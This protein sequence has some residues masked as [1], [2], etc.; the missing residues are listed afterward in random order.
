MGQSGQQSLIT[1]LIKI[2]FATAAE[3][4]D[5][6]R[7]AG[8][9]RSALGLDY[10]GLRSGAYKNGHFGFIELKLETPEAVDID[11]V[12]EKLRAHLTLPET[13]TRAHSSDEWN[14][15]I[16]GRVPVIDHSSGNQYGV[17]TVNC[18]ILGELN[19]ESRL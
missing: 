4:K 16:S 9:V 11:R 19:P 1:K 2:H 15:V 12:A 6:A 18:E 7:Y 10:H 17:V 3:W 5:T 8:F 14:A 13:L